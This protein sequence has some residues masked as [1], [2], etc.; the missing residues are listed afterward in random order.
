MNLTKVVV[1]GAGEGPT[2]ADLELLRAGGLADVT[3]VTVYPTPPSGADG[4]IGP[5]PSLPSR[6][7][8]KARRVRRKTK[9][10]IRR[11]IRHARTALSTR[12]HDGSDATAAPS[13]EE[14]AKPPA[15]LNKRARQRLEATITEVDAVLEQNPGVGL[16]IALDGLSAR[17]AWHLADRHADVLAVQGI[18]AAL[19]LT[20]GRF[21][22]RLD[23]TPLAALMDS[24]QSVYSALPD[25]DR[26]RKR[27]LV[28]SPGLSL[29]QVAAVA[30]ARPSA[31]VIGVTVGE[32]VGLSLAPNSRGLLVRL[33]A[34]DLAPPRWPTMLR[35]MAVDETITDLDASSFDV[36]QTPGSQVPPTSVLIAPANYAGQGAAWAQALGRH[37]GIEARNLSI[38]PPTSPFVFPADIPMTSEDWA[39][40][41]VR[42]RAALEAVLP[43]THVFIEAL[44]PI[45]GLGSSI[46][47]SA[48]D[49]AA[50]FADAQA[51]RS[52]GR[53]V[54]VVIHGSEGRRPQDHA[55]RYRHSPFART[56]HERETQARTRVSDAVHT[57]IAEL[58]VPVLV[59][60]PDMLDFV[61]GATWL[62][63]VVGPT[64]FK[65][66]RPLFTAPLPVVM[67]APSSGPLK[68][69]EHID[70]ELEELD[71]QG[72]IEYRRLSHVPPSLV[73]SYLR[74]ADIVVDQI[75]LGNPGVL[76][77]QA[78]ACGRVVV[79]HLSDEVRARFDSSIPVVEATP[80]TLGEVIRGLIAD[81]VAATAAG[82]AGPEF[83]R[84]H[85]DGRR[86]A[87]VLL[88]VLSRM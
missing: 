64:S 21:P 80:D 49:T 88:D 25:L 45:L 31:D 37:A 69:S 42:A 85:H 82:A 24:P 29:D 32:P 57:L 54:A 39:H 34:T 23:L 12:L 36:P 60:T 59:T 70:R 50:G 75:V 1:L 44:R 43:A 46:D 27:V 8:N 14:Q 78:M 68:G 73:A 84:L 61:P 13:A 67:H 3:A 77:A 40:P 62:P 22:P 15:T 48:W 87:Q 72:L 18:D 28:N 30:E 17:V 19:H 53:H 58:D 65:P 10:A 47:V 6:V 26:Y 55:A 79:A 9:K 71:R 5:P 81:Q 20:S 56:E 35:T 41:A 16:L 33:T 52:S 7:S 11:R 63:I 2:D 83:T 4:R 76:A 86:S 66:G 74:D 38:V 51:L